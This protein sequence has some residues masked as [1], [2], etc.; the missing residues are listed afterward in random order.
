MLIS[1]DNIRIT[2]R[3]LSSELWT[4]HAVFLCCTN[5]IISITPKL[6]A[7]FTKQPSY[8]VLAK[9]AKDKMAMF[10]YKAHLR[11]EALCHAEYQCMLT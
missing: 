3:F 1:W 2:Q 9:I 6:Q 5:A 11:M 4:I 7:S 10:N 8:V